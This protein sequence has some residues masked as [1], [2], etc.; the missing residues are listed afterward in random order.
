[1]FARLVH[2]SGTRVF[3]VVYVL[4]APAAAPPE[5]SPGP[6]PP[7]APPEVIFAAASAEAPR[8]VGVAIPGTQL[9]K[10]RS[11]LKIAAP[12]DKV[13]ATVLD[14]A[15]YPEFMPH[16]QK[17][18]VLSRSRDGTRE[19]Y[20]EVAALHG[21]VTMWARIEVAKAT[22]VDGVE[23]HETKFIEGNIKDLKATWRLKKIDEGAT[24]L[25]LDIFLLPRLPVPDR[26]VN[27]ENLDGSAAA[28]LAIKRR[29]LGR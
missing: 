24:E 28:V 8:T 16:Y 20:M 18:R 29:V 27:N 4:G 2:G 6:S 22:V 13:R 9:V 26:V 5:A 3:S 10:G 1:M 14:F 25:T 17:C 23:I 11:T 15:H 12:I 19:V 7:A 21:V